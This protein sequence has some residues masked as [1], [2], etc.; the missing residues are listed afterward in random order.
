M[1][2]LSLSPEVILKKWKRS[3]KA[4]KL[5][6]VFQLWRLKF[7][8]SLRVLVILY[9]VQIKSI[10]QGQS[11][12]KICW[13][14][15]SLLQ[16]L[17]HKHLQNEIIFYCC[18]YQ[19]FKHFVKSDSLFL[20]I[21]TEINSF[22]FNPVLDRDFRKT[23]PGFWDFVLLKFFAFLLLF[24]QLDLFILDLFWSYF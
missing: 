11:K 14:H 1:L 9:Q 19:K 22:P 20:F 3:K 15:F 6:Q 7:N 5:G 21:S 12:K 13:F 10:I 17:K 24:F 18:L 8:V 23:F 4:Q 16:V 2:N